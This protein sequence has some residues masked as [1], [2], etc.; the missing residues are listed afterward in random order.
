MRLYVSRKMKSN[1]TVSRKI[2][3]IP[4][5]TTIRPSSKRD[6]G[7]NRFPINEAPR[8]SFDSYQEPIKR[9]LRQSFFFL[10]LTSARMN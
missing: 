5:V 6:L 8:G 10:G 2:S 1:L 4:T 9:E 3:K 7:F